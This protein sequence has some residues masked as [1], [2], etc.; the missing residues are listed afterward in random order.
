MLRQLLIVV[1]LSVVGTRVARLVYLLGFHKT[2]YKHYP[3]PC[4]VVPGLDTG[5]EDITVSG[6]GLAFISSGLRAKGGEPDG[7]Q[8]QMGRIY[9][10]DF[11]HPEKNVAELPLTGNID[12]DTLRP[13]G[14]SLY[15]DP[16]TGEVRL[17]VVNH[18]SN[19]ERIEIFRFDENSRSLNHLKTVTG[20]YI[21]SVNDIV[22]VGHNS[23]YY[24]NDKYFTSPAGKTIELFGL[25]TWGTVGFYDGTQD[26]LVAEGYGIPNGLNI[27]PDGRYIYVASSLQEQIIVF[28]RQEDGSLAETQR[29]DAWTIVDNIEVDKL[30]GDLW[31]GCH[32]AYNLLWKHA[33]NT[34]RPAGSQV[35]RLTFDSKGAAY[36]NTEFREVFMD[37]GSLISG[38]SVASYYDDKILIGTVFEKTAFCEIKAF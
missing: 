4:R 15:E 10:F 28:E 3:G 33:Q 36:G 8:R 18:I 35:L 37:D 26:R 31:I 23:F 5:S 9:L 16:E 22:A 21:Y 12:R 20:E 38:S 7:P 24:T 30:T 11:N 1:V 17:F 32:P 34:T 13:H 14:I 6:S 27:S 19:Q 2:I 25:L 29:I